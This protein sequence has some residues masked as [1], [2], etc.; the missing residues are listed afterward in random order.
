M[1]IFSLFDHKNTNMRCL[2]S[3]S[4]DATF[5]GYLPYIREFRKVVKKC[6]IVTGCPRAEKPETLLAFWQMV[7]EKKVNYR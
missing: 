5:A 4:L 1:T 6:V 7:L 2:I 3:V